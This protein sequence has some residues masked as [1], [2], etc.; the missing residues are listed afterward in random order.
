[1]QRELF[2]REVV[3]KV[4]RVTLTGHERLHIEQHGGLVDYDPENIVF[5]TSVGLMQISGAGMVFSLYSAGE[6]IV[7]GRIDG[8]FF[9]HREDAR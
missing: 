7:T 8:V 1:M 4:P 6:A 5:R 3:S 2:P 9:Q